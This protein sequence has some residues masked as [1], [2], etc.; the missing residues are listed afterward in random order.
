M[1]QQS[2]DELLLSVGD[3]IQFEDERGEVA[4]GEVMEVS[5]VLNMVKVMPL[6]GLL[7]IPKWIHADNILTDDDIEFVFQ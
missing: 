5:E 3:T 1:Y 7:I 2:D 6:S 4:E